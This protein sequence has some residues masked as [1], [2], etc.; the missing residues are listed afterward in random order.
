[1]LEGGERG[2]FLS[3]VSFP[4]LSIWQALKK[5]LVDFIVVTSEKLRVKKKNNS[6]NLLALALW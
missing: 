2:P 1:M 5:H 4:R 6:K 3:V